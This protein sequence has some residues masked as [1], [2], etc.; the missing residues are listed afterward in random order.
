[1]EE[2]DKMLEDV[3]TKLAQ[4]INEIRELKKYKKSLLIAK[5]MKAKLERKSVRKNKSDFGSK[6]SPGADN[7]HSQNT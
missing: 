2:L 1:M 7:I 6:N 5:N 4:K 3:E